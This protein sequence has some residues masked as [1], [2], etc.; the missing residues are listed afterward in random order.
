MNESE[1]ARELVGKVL[2]WNVVKDF[3][4]DGRGIVKMI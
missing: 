2:F 1:E 4:L 3:S